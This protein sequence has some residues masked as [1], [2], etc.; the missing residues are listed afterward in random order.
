MKFTEWLA[1]LVLA[2]MVGGIAF[3][4]VF[5]GG[6]G[7]DGSERQTTEA[8]PTLTFPIKVF[9]Q[10]GEPPLVTE[11][12]QHGHQDFWFVNESGQNLEV[13]LNSKGC[14][15]SEVEIALA[16]ESWRAYGDCMSSTQALQLPLRR[17]EG[18]TMLAALNARE[19][20]FPELA[21]TNASSLLLTKEN[22]FLVPAGALGRVRLSWQQPQARTL[23]T[24]ADL[25]IGQRGGAVNARIDA[26]V[27]V[28]DPVVIAVREVTLPSVSIREL[29]YLEKEKT[30]QRGWIICGSLTRQHVQ[31]QAEL[32]RDGIKPEADPF[33][34]GA[35]LPLDKADLSKLAK[36]FGDK[37]PTILAGLKFP[38]TLKAHAKD[39]TP[40]QWGHFLRNVKMTSEE[41]AEP[42]V[43]PVTG[44]VLG[45]VSIGEAGKV[46]GTLDLGP[47]PRKR[48]TN[49]T[50]ILQT[51]EKQL[52]LELDKTR[53][54]DY[55]KATLSEPEETAAGHRLWKLRVEVPPGAAQGEFPRADPR[56]RDSAVY[57][58]TK[59]K[60]PHSLRVPIMGTANDR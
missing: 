52:Q 7:P 59:G 47:F 34:V 42:V 11:V 23:N 55:F 49:G 27:L 21:G 51:D 10:E 15:C 14:T 50:V 22:A 26:R 16:P 39:G 43:V 19:H 33:E 57:I 4:V 48:G 1:V 58:K 13:G 44:R 60:P 12:Q 41:G 36:E 46:R 8:L 56:Y 45:D 24:F 18:L 37:M 30:G 20:R 5:R 54:A 31:A 17:L 9:P 2:L 25:W 53:S 32:L 3:V 38:V 28:S 40:A 29:E 6:G 35:P